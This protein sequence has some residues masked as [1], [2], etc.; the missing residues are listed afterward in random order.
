[1]GLPDGAVEE[2]DSHRQGPLHGSS[3]WS[4]SNWQGL[5]NPFKPAYD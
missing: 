1:M 2:E 3:S 4:A 5:L